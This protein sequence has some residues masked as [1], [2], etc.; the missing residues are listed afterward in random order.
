MNI[1]D[2]LEKELLN[3]KQL[4]EKNHHRKIIWQNSSE[5]KLSI[6]GCLSLFI[7]L[8]MQLL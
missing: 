1:K 5:E 4:Q 8:F 2:N 7:Y 3:I 6:T